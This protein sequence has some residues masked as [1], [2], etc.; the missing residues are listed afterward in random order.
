[1]K[2]IL[3]DLAKNQIRET[4]NYISRE[5]GKKSRDIFIQSVRETKELLVRNPLIGPIEPLL[6]NRTENYRS[7]VI[8]K[9]N[10]MVYS[11]KGD[12]INIVAFWDCRREPNSLSKDVENSQS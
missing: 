9:L 3:S 7:L 5:F 10:K 11:I 1:M 8:G 4:A 6:T 12:S 2:V